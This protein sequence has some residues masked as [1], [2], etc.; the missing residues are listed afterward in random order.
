MTW[1]LI[2]FAVLASAL[3]LYAVVVE[4][5]DMPRCE[6]GQ[7]WATCLRHH[8][9]ALGLVLV[10]AGAGM[11]AFRLLA[12]LP[13]DLLSLA[14]VLGVTLIYLSR[15]AEWLSYL[16][17]GDRRRPDTVPGADRRAR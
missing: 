1:L 17:R 8:V 11:H 13:V 16:L 14:M 5:N 3:L 15:S 6:R 10:G 9:R 2:T 12:G 4:L 7:C